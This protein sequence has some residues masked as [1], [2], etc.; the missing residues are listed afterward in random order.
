MQC[1][2]DADQEPSEEVIA[3][4]QKRI[5]K[6]QQQKGRTGGGRHSKRHKKR[7]R[8]DSDSDSDEVHWLG[9]PQGRNEDGLPTSAPPPTAP[10]PT[11]KTPGNAARR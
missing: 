4:A 8:D 7:K 11:G 6:Q 9:T 2:I 5:E 3:I 10:H 1:I